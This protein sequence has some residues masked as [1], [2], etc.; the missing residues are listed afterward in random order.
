MRATHRL[1]LVLVAASI[2]T[3]GCGPRPLVFSPDE[4][5]EAQVGQPYE[6]TITV[7]EAATPVFEISI[8]S[9]ELPP[10]LSLSYE[11]I[12]DVAVI[13]GIP[14]SAGEFELVAKAACFGTNSPGQVGEKTY[15]LSVK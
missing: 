15:T 2:L 1:L 11:S 8:K 5:P 13:Q 6:A 3:S 10:G 14:E 12:N 4:L 7:S 9:S